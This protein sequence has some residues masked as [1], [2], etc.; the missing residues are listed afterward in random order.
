MTLG[1][2]NLILRIQE[3]LEG[4]AN[5]MYLWIYL[6]LESDIAQ[7]SIDTENAILDLG[8]TCVTYLN[9]G[10]FNTQLSKACNSAPWQGISPTKII[11]N[12]LAKDSMSMKLAL[13]LLRGGKSTNC[14]V[15]KQLERVAALAN[16]APELIHVF[17]PYAKAYV[18][19][20][21]KGLLACDAELDS[22]F[23]KIFNGYLPF[24]PK[25]WSDEE[26][27]TLGNNAISLAVD[28]NHL[29]LIYRI[30]R[31]N[32]SGRGQGSLGP[33]GKFKNVP[34]RVLDNL[35]S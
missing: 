26:G 6:Q 21:T 11:K 15:G 18:L 35:L 1:D 24:V 34:E 20:H 12:S 33:A 5:G 28:H 17:L 23:Y 7:Y 4:R 10:I 22:M 3:E 13:S 29:G 2:P 31:S 30:L 8:I 16:P 9:L 27:G 19:A 14:D 32:A 25:P